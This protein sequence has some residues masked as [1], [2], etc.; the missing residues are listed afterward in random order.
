[1]CQGTGRRT[2]AQLALVRKETLATTFDL[3]NKGQITLEDMTSTD[4]RCHC[5]YGALGRMGRSK[6]AKLF[7]QMRADGWQVEYQPYAGG[8]WQRR[9]E[10]I[11]YDW[12]K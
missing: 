9:R 7:Q 3:I 5:H 11:V 4:F 2:I 1:M 10:T 6:R 8:F 12:L